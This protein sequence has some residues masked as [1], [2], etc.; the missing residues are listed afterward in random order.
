MADIITG[1][2][3]EISDGSDT[4]YAMFVQLK[5]DI[6]ISPTIK[7]YSGPT[8]FGYSLLKRHWVFKFTKVLLED[9][10]DFS[11]FIDYVLDWQDSAPFTLKVKRADASYIEF[12]GDNTSYTV[13]VA[14]DGIRDIEKLSKGDQDGPYQIGM[15][16]LEQAG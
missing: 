4:I 11:N 13:M 15:L 7:H 14:K 5:V 9:H 10:T 1:G 12:D 2:Y 6:K 16:I 8:N 3:M